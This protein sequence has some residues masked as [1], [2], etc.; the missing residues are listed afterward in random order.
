MPV[1]P[2]SAACLLL[3]GS[4][5][6]ASLLGCT[7]RTTLDASPDAMAPLRVISYNIR[8]NNPGDG[9][10]AWPERR[11]RVA[12]LLR[13]HDA[14]LIGVQEALAGQIADLD[15][16]LPRHAW[17][18]VGRDD[19]DTTG[20]YSA[21]FYRTDRLELLDEG[22]FWLSPTPS[23]PG[24]RGWDAAITRIA[25]WARFRDLQSGTAFVHLNTHFDHVG[26]EARTESAR[27][28]V[29]WLGVVD[30][31]TPVVVTGDFNAAPD[32]PPYEVLTTAL[33]DAR[34]ASEQEPY[35][36]GGT[37]SSFDVTRPLGP[38]I[39][40]VFVR[41]PV[42]V[43]QQATLTESTEARYPSDHLPVLADLQWEGTSMP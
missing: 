6:A 35:G 19:G 43:V 20:E 18:G 30:G 40:Y 16:A 42:Q 28:I 2:P 8:Y 36:P 5:L 10:N 33:R 25:T 12:A 31:T 11:A 14:D 1:R 3:L 39:D 4:L 22:T 24:S 34:V 9:I 41:G 37:F 38:R 17:L 26:T 23:V 15:A 13:F 32:S 27:L 7:A 21:I 29:E